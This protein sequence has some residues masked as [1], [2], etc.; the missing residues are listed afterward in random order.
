MIQSIHMTYAPT[1]L[2]TNKV[3]ADGK[4]TA[5][6]YTSDGKL[7]TR[8][9]ARGVTTTY[10][11]NDAGSL[12]NIVY[13]DATPDVTFAY[14]RLGR[15][16]SAIV[17]GVS[18]NL[19]SYAILGQL[20]N[21]TVSLCA[22][23][24]LR[25]AISRTT[26][27]LGRDTGFS[28]GP[29]YAVQYG[30][31]AYG[32]FHSVTSSI[33]S[34][35]STYTYGYLPGT[36]LI[37]GMTA[38]SGFLW[39]R[40]YESARS[41]ITSVENRYGETVISRYDYTN[42]E[43]G[44][45]TSRAD[46]GLAFANPA[47]DAYSYNGRS[48][49]TGAQRY[50]GTDISDT[51]TVYGG[52]Q[53]GYVYDPIGNRTSASETIGGETLA[54]TYTANALNQYTVIA[55]PDAVGLRG[56]ATNT[57]VVTV[58][59]EAVQHDTVTSESIPWHFALEADNTD[60]PDFPFAE[61][62][63]VVN[64]PGTNTPDIVSTVS[65]HAYAPPQSETL[66]YDLDGNLLSDGRWQY[67]W[68][69]ENRLIKAEEQVSPTNRQPYMVEYAYDH[70]GRMVWKEI[71]RRDGETQSWETE[72]AATL[73]WDG[74]NI[75][76]TTIHHSSFTN[77]HFFT[78][79]LDL[80]GSI[81]GAGGVGGLLAEVKDGEPYFAAFDA[82]GNV[83]EYI[84]TNGVTEAH[85]EYSPFGE[86]VVQ[87]GDLAASFTHRFST[88]PW[89]AVTGLSEYEY[90]KYGP[91]M[92]RWLSRDPIE[93]WGG[94]NIVAAMGNNLVSYWDLLGLA[95]ITD[96]N[97]VSKE[98]T[99]V[100][101]TGHGKKKK[102]PKYNKDDD[103]YGDIEDVLTDSDIGSAAQKYADEGY[104][105]IGLIGCWTAQTIKNIDKLRSQQKNG[106][107]EGSVKPPIPWIH[108]MPGA[109]GSVTWRELLKDVTGEMWEPG[110]GENLN[111]GPGLG[112]S[113][114]AHPDY[115]RNFKKA[116]EP[117]IQAGISKKKDSLCCAGCS[118]VRIVKINPR[119]RIIG[120]DDTETCR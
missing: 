83:T 32:R 16:V 39:T 5:Y 79:G 69:G 88:K 74:Y 97:P 43:L 70:Q 31:D 90:R 75:V 119:G 24:P 41:L 78:W 44:R 117:A 12:T 54:K 33:E 20:T 82:N 49:V 120:R 114:K 46:S 116:I 71:K 2:L 112:N 76:S 14:D 113:Y 51:S 100:I 60:G 104:G 68:N 64:P 84:S 93:E 92:G 7:A 23:A 25:E 96:P 15:Q 22:S 10:A 62:V 86:I 11:H 26:D 81:Q 109:E 85:Y 29:D 80:S 65:G 38:S 53:F 108:T 58:N 77:H 91:G 4:G 107:K 18:T 73:I 6:N 47:F 63:A 34:T 9:W 102:N 48:E 30:Y 118:Q 89:C 21:E 66:T 59:S 67:T 17:D 106:E 40:A 50:H 72:K 98:C 57:A 55:N 28:L 35:S 111:E 13:S 103:Y 52:R 8:A 101:I 36:D 19:Y 3:Y 110:P 61:I 95:K 45:R 87:S 42:D 99:I 56:D 1:G 105:G 27:A 94:W 115:P 37:S